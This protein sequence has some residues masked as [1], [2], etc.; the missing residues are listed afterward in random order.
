MSFIDMTS[1]AQTI[2]N[3]QT[4]NPLCFGEFT[5][6]STINLNQTSPPTDVTVKLYWQ[7]P[8]TGFWIN[9]GNQFS[10]FPA[11]VTNFPFL[12]LSAANYRID[13]INTVS[14]V[15][16]DDV[17]FTLNDPPAISISSSI[18]NSISCYNSSDGSINLSII[19]GI[20][21]YSYSWSNGAITQNLSN[22]SAGQYI[23]TVTDINNCSL[24]DTIIVSEPN[25]L[26][27]SGFVSQSII[28]FGNANGEIT[29]QINGGTPPY[30]YSINNGFFSTNN[31]F[32]NLSASNYL[33]TYE[34]LNSCTI[35]ENI[36]LDNPILL[37]G[38]VTILSPVTC[39]SACDGSIKF[40]NNN[41]GTPP[42]TYSLNGGPAQASN[43]FDNLCGD[44]LYY[45][46]MMDSQN[47]NLVDTIYLTQPTPLL[48][49]VSTTN[50]NGLGVA[51]NGGI[52]SIYLSNPIGGNGAPIS[53]SFDGGITF[54]QS[55]NQGGLQAG[56]Y[57]LAIKDALGCITYDSTVLTE[58]LPITIST[59][60]ND[61]SC[62]SL[63]DGSINIMPSGGVL[64]F[65]YFWNDGQI[66]QQIVGLSVDTFSCIIIDANGCNVDTSVIITEPDVL[67][68]TSTIIDNLIPFSALA[69]ININISGGTPTYTTT[70]NG[71]NN[72][73]S[74]DSNIDS[75]FAGFYYLSI[76]DE[77]S[78]IFLDTL[79]VIDPIAIFGCTDLLALNYDPYSN[80]ENGMCYYCNLNY[81]LFS[82]MPSSPVS[83][84]GWMSVYVPLGSYP[85]NYFWSNGDT[86]WSITGLCNDTFS[87]TIIDNNLCGADTTLLLS[88]F[89]GCMDDTM[90]NYDPLVL[91]NDSSC[92]PYV[93]GCTD[94]TQFN[95]DALANTSDGSCEAYVY[96]CDSVNA[97][98]YNPLV[99][100]NDGSCW[101]CVYGCMDQTMFNFD[102]T[103]TCNDICITVTYGCIDSLA[104]NY[105]SLANTSDGSCIPYLAGCTDIIAINFDVSANFDDGSCCFISGCTDSTMY[106]YS[107]LACF[108]DSSC[109]PF[110]YGCTD[111]LSFN[112]DTMANIN[113]TSCYVCSFTY[114]SWLIDTTNINTCG[115]FAGI[116][117]LVS[118]NSSSLNYT[119]STLYGSYPVDISQPFLG[120]L[121]LG[122]YSLSVVDNM[123]CVFSDTI[124]IGNVV[125]GCIDS[126]ACNYNP[127]ANVDDGSCLSTYGCMDDTA[128]NYDL[129]A[130]CDDGSCLT[131]Y[132]CMDDTACNYDLSATCDDGS[133]DLPNGCGDSLYLEYV[134]SVTCSD[135]NACLTLIVLG[136]TDPLAD[137]YYAGATIDD[138]SCTYPSICINPTPTGAYV[139][140]LIHDRVR[141]NWDN[142]NDTS[143]SCMITQYRI[144]YR[145]VG[146]STWLSKTMANSGLCLFGLN[147]TSKRIKGLTPSTTYEY[148]MKAWYCGGGVSTWSAIQN[149][150]TADECENVLNFAVST[151]TTIKAEFTWDTTGAYSFA[152]IKL[153][154]DT[155]GGV[156][157]FAGGFGVFYPAI[158]KDKNGL[159]PGTSYRAQARTWCDLT[160]GAYRSTA[161]SPLIFWTQPTSIRLEGGSS[162]NSL[163]IYPNPSRDKF[164]VSFTSDTKQDLKVRILNVIGEELI[165]ENLQQF[166]GEYTKQIDL[167]NNAKG[168]YFLEIETDKGIVN[169][170]LILQ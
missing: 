95:Y 15:L 137:N 73:F 46:S 18:S 39:N 5:G 143:S 102:S 113:D 156:W 8:N 23:A 62:N 11:Y 159:T 150:T 42:Y 60:V 147:T 135:A 1:N 64:P 92:V 119:W 70:W 169:K 101:Y 45:I 47:G 165:Y 10:N 146:T 43:I 110:I 91:F 16:L 164:N 7:N 55:W 26:Q 77:N 35:S 83:C 125:L 168:I 123:G 44:S 54:I 154:V 57:T 2:T 126:F 87:V 66:S 56:N 52:G 69:A 98:N 53:Y 148:Y 162:I 141:V 85:I 20:G 144:R 3:I 29:A 13:L 134:S 122:I 105:D 84:D 155:T 4:S 118:I 115:A 40:V 109:I 166:I 37:S 74:T 116:N 163:A 71:P 80:V 120:N 108:D 112:Y 132:G 68:A 131:T 65:S 100:T 28:G 14:G 106:N 36:I 12:S 67:L 76:Q 49:S 103:A 90:F 50:F 30:N 51:C 149:F 97:V 167:S 25:L 158:S 96:G 63:T 34:D 157:T 9:L 24:N 32:Q 86:S 136:C 38:Y 59:Q 89:V 88:N 78:C 17:F 133:C 128:C 127:L 160:G 145:E 129:S 19:G 151:P 21:S 104:I 117:N 22:I 41:S 75:L 99:N 138:G 81:N 58:P 161:W 94:S 82:Y 142:M 111:S 72:F 152:R 48:F 79:E 93:F 140:E 139:T 170:K 31:L 124:E 27:T 121:C 107:S 153:R 33:I 114:N 61:V 6:N 130:T